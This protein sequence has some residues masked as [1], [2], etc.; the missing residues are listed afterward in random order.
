MWASK[1]VLRAFSRVRR[2][3]YTNWFRDVEI[4]LRWAGNATP[5]IR[6]VCLG[7]GNDCGVF[8][9][10]ALGLAW[11]W[12]AGLCALAHNSRI[13][14]DAHP[15]RH[16]S[17]HQSVFRLRKKLP[18]MRWL[19]PLE[20]RPPGC[21][22]HVHHLNIFLEYFVMPAHRGAIRT[23][24]FMIMLR[25]YVPRQ[26]GLPLSGVGARIVPRVPKCIPY[27]FLLSWPIAPS[28]TTELL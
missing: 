26:F 12:M 13:G 15:W 7:F 10:D 14:F 5:T 19:S 22:N 8:S 23:T 25:T 4:M 6:T 3:S 20:F 28:S 17:I 16:P 18:V 27:L 24:R 1:I 21:Q 11:P 2:P 9:A